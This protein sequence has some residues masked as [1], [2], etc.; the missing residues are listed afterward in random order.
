MYIKKN[1]LLRAKPS[2]VIRLAKYLNLYTD[3]MSH[4]QVAKL[5]Y[6]RITRGISL[7]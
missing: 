5:V 4:H 7:Y 2:N 1:T 3:Q 6:W